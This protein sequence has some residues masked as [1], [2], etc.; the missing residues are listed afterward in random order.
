MQPLRPPA[1]IA[2]SALRADALWSRVSS[3]ARPT[4]PAPQPRIIPLSGS[5]DA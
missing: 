1:R 5:Y 4:Q 2:G 3:S